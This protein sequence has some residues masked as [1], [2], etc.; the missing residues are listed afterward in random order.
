MVRYGQINFDYAHYNF[1][2]LL[3]V[4][5]LSNSISIKFMKWFMVFG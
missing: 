4:S 2:K 5:L 1:F 3:D